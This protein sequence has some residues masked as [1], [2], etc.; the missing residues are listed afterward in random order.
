MTTYGTYSTWCQGIVTAGEETMIVNGLS[1]CPSSTTAFTFGPSEPVDLTW[2]NVDSTKISVSG[3]AAFTVSAEQV[4][5]LYRS[6]DLTAAVASA[7]VGS[8]AATPT[9]GGASSSA[10]SSGGDLSTAATAGIGIAAAALGI[11]AVLGAF[12]LFLRHRRGK[13]VMSGR[14]QGSAKQGPAG[15]GGIMSEGLDA[16][17]QGTAA[18]VPVS[19]QSRYELKAADLDSPRSSPAL[20]TVSPTRSA[21]MVE[22]QG[23]APTHSGTQA[24]SGLPPHTIG[25]HTLAGGKLP[26]AYEVSGQGANYHQ[27]PGSSTRVTMDESRQN[28]PLQMLRPDKGGVGF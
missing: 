13:G 16:Q 26:S 14:N 21:G 20:A 19:T 2:V 4:V 5:L 24:W 22:L 17:P 27:L 8:S 1:E 25:E 6:S 28:T 12:Y 18:R 11:A 15:G 23:S 3:A 10:Q 7:T 9:G